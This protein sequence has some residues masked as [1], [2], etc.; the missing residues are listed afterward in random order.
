MIRQSTGHVQEKIVLL[1][2]TLQFLYIL[3]EPCQSL[4][5]ISLI[6][7]NRLINFALRANMLGMRIFILMINV[8]YLPDVR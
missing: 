6:V 7:I 3:C 8:Q 1:A 2:R 4:C 5:I